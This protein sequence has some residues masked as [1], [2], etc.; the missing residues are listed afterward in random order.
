M[1][2]FDP[3]INLTLTCRYNFQHIRD[4]YTL[5]NKLRKR[6][7]KSR[8]KRYYPIVKPN[9]WQ[10]PSNLSYATKILILHCTLGTN[11][12][13]NSFRISNIIRRYKLFKKNA[14]TEAIFWYARCITKWNYTQHS[15]ITWFVTYNDAHCR[16]PSSQQWQ[17]AIR[18]TTDFQE[19]IRSFRKQDLK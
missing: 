5:P 4:Y 10:Y 14:S 8:L 19:G 15:S 18:E 13:S 6:G 11:L 2:L 16:S 9:T 1:L 3:S 17:V 12:E 7:C